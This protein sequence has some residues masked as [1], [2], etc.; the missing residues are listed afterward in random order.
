MQ[1]ISV[2]PAPGDR[3]LTRKRDRRE[4]K[5]DKTVR[6][7]AV[8]V[9]HLRALPDTS[10]SFFIEGPKGRSAV[11]TFLNNYD[12]ETQSL[13]RG[14]DEGEYLFG[15][16]LDQIFSGNRKANSPLRISIVANKL[17]PQCVEIYW[18]EHGREPVTDSG[19]LLQMA[20]GIERSEIRWK[21]CRS[22][23]S[24]QLNDQ[25]ATTNLR[26]ALRHS[27]PNPIHQAL[28]ERGLY[29]EAAAYSKKQ[30][31][32]ALN[33][34]SKFDAA[35]W[36]SIQASDQ[37]ALGE[38]RT[39]IRT[40]EKAQSYIRDHLRQRPPSDAA[41][42]LQVKIEFGMTVAHRSM[43]NGDFMGALRTHNQLNRKARVL[44]KRAFDSR[45]QRT[46]RE[47]A[48]HTARQQAE[49][50]RYT[51]RYSRARRVAAKLETLYPPGDYI[52]KFWCQVYQA[53]NLRLL[54]DFES[55]SEILAA[56]REQAAGGKRDVARISILWRLVALETVHATGA[57][58][59]LLAETE[60]MLEQPAQNMLS[61]VYPNLA[62]AAARF[63]EHNRATAYLRLA[64]SAAQWSP[65]EQLV[66]F[67]YSQMIRGEV[68]RNA[69]RVALARKMFKSALRCFEEAGVVWGKVRACIGLAECGETILPPT[70]FTRLEGL[71]AV[72]WAEHIAGNTPPPGVLCANFP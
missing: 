45:L 63:H 17:E 16:R 72:L 69:R 70:Q 41:E 3:T 58:D 60:R 47:Y 59:E 2:T 64:S 57:K 15:C 26:P 42:V 14:A 54:G 6:G 27:N 34:P 37:R 25:G 38:I 68:A 7:F 23:T 36:A 35:W 19:V 11:S 53:D 29:R 62:L 24:L 66:E 18:T 65:R 5:W 32:L 67:A 61:R 22:A 8:I 28:K 49:C 50:L 13:N 10:A 33:G 56:L 9:L 51:G 52:P 48:L 1:A 31:R 46:A 12:K 20:R 44:A 43:L 30:L 39:A 71:D 55:A 40:L 21:K 4:F